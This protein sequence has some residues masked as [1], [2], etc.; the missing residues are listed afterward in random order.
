MSGNREAPPSP[1]LAILSGLARADKV[2]RDGGYI[3]RPSVCCGPVIPNKLKGGKVERRWCGRPAHIEVRR[4]E[5]PDEDA[6]GNPRVK[7]VEREVVL[8]L[9]ETC[10]ID[11][12]EYRDSLRRE[13]ER[14]PESATKNRRSGT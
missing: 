1:V 9:C 11:E 10:G 7:T 12:R 4:E 14:P 6:Q 5:M 3:K 13:A 2:Q 8:G